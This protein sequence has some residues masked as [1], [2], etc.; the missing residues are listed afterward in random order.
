VRPVGSLY[1]LVELGS[2]AR[3]SL[4]EMRSIHP[5]FAVKASTPKAAK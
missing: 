1:W 4:K 3:F 2:I 5:R